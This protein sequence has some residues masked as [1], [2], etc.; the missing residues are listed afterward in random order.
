MLQLCRSVPAVQPAL[1]EQ[2]DLSYF[3]IWLL[4][5]PAGLCRHVHPRG[6][7]PDRGETAAWSTVEDVRM[8]W[9]TPRKKEP[10]WYIGMV[11][12]WG[13]NPLNLS[14]SSLKSLSTTNFSSPSLATS[15]SM[16]L[17]PFSLGGK[18][19]ACSSHVFYFS[20]TPSHVWHDVLGLPCSNQNLLNTSVFASS[21]TPWHRHHLLKTRPQ[22]LPH[23]WKLQP[24][25]K[26]KDLESQHIQ[27]E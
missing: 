24:S 2:V 26:T 22:H 3:Q 5:P 10:S 7:P 21:K 6:C 19:P 8:I 1:L 15:H 9:N 25:Y 4:W 27:Y 14:P 16:R 20:S 13:S 12:V 17:L 18:C 23:C 11:S